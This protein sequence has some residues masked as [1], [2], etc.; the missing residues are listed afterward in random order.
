[1]INA[2]NSTKVTISS[3]TSTKSKTGECITKFKIQVTNLEN[4][5]LAIIALHNLQDIYDV[6]RVFK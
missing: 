3:V 1:M 6:E 5:H 2:L 4:L